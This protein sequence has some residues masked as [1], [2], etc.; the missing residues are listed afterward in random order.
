M[1]L[2]HF[3]GKH[4][5]FSP[6]TAFRTPEQLSL[7]FQVRDVRSVKFCEEFLTLDSK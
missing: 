7:F 2:G 3:P 4:F 5:Q 6:G 1:N